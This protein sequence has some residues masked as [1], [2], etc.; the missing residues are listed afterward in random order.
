M[1][2]EVNIM[3]DDENIAV[4]VAKLETKFDTHASEFTKTSKKVDEIYD[5]M[6]QAKGAKWAILGFAGISGFLGG[7]G[8]ALVSALFSIK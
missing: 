2:L 8:S 3:S 7:K 5:L 4:K 1:Q 6:N